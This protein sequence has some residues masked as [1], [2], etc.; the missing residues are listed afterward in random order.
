MSSQATMPTMPTPL[1]MLTLPCPAPPPPPQG[2]PHNARPQVH[3]LGLPRL[4]PDVWDKVV[5]NLGSDDLVPLSQTCRG[6]RRAVSDYCRA[7]QSAVPAIPVSID[8]SDCRGNPARA[9]HHAAMFMQL[10]AHWGYDNVHARITGVSDV[11]SLLVAVAIGTRVALHHHRRFDEGDDPT[12]VQVGLD[13]FINP[14]LARFDMARYS[15]VAYVIAHRRAA[16][17]KAFLDTLRRR[18][19]VAW[20]D[21]TR[22]FDPVPRSTWPRHLIKKRKRKPR[23]RAQPRELGVCSACAAA[24]KPAP[25]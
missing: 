21:G 7:N 5:D 15:P 13:A 10:A 2:D 23:A 11:P 20:H 25:L 24:T 22:L 4:P 3:A 9:G 19:T 16:Q 12:P 14:G 8:M 18:G 6:L 1:P 17:Y